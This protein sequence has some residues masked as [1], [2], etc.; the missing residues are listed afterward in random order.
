MTMLTFSPPS[1]EMRS[2]L[3]SSTKGTPFMKRSDD[4]ILT[5]HVGSL[6]RPKAL[7][8]LIQV[9]ESGEPYDHAEFARQAKAA[10][11]DVVKRQVEC[12]IDIVNDGEQA[13]ASFQGYF[14]ERLAGF[15][16]KP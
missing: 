14:L 4:R 15:E 6:A 5:T 12:G 13:K 11:A 7:I 3:H 2:A 9:K 16:R 10:V 8:D 1:E